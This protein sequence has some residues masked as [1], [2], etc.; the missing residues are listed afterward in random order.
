LLDA[1]VVRDRGAVEGHVEVDPDEHSQP[2]ELELFDT[3]D[4]VEIG[5]LHLLRGLL[6]AVVAG[7]L[8]SARSAAVL[9]H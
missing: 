4:S 7:Q 8:E 9:F 5:H 2:I 1:E 6:P 3:F